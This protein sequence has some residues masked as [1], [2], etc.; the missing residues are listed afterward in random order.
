MWV[1]C[2]AR[3]LARRYPASRFV[4]FELAEASALRTA[5]LV[6]ERH[7]LSN[8]RFQQND[9]TTLDGADKFDLILT[10]DAIHDQVR[11]DLALRAIARSLKPGGVYVGVDI[12]GSSTLADNL[13]DPLNVLV[14]WPHVLHD[15]P[16]PTAGWPRH[17]VR[18]NG[19]ER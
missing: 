3:L 10:F 19:R 6:A 5:R 4:G 13:D 1:G 18:R 8:V 14:R 2:P 9:A 7:R 15:W 11:P 16:P 12:A 17:H